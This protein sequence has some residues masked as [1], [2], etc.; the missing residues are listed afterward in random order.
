MVFFLEITNMWQ[1]FQD[2][3]SAETEAVLEMFYE[4]EDNQKLNI[5]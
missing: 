3:W 5:S 2:F 4:D 1:K